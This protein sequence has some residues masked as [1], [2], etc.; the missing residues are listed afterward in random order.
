M[1]VNELGVE[2]AAALH[3]P[4]AQRECVDGS[5]QHLE[6]PQLKPAGTGWVARKRARRRVLHY[7]T[8]KLTYC[9]SSAYGRHV[10][11]NEYIFP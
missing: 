1:T 2:V 7:G 6:M 4:R 10:G 11:E 5:K 3:V 9:I 8:G